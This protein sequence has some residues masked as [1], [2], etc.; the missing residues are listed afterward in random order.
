VRD[1][2]EAALDPRT[3]HGA[4]PAI[5]PFFPMLAAQ[6]KSEFL[7]LARAPAFTIPTIIFPIMF[8]ALFGLPHVDEQFGNS[9]VGRFMLASFGAYAVISVALFSFG[10]TVAAER[11]RK[12]TALMRSTPL[13][14]LAY[15]GGKTLATIA[16][17]LVTLIALF[18]FGAGVGGVRLETGQ[19]LA[20][21][22]VLLLGVFPFITLGFAVGYLAGGNSAVAILNL[23]NLPMAFGSG[24]FMPLPMLPLAVQQIAPYLPA[25]HYGQLAWSAVGAG[26]EPPLTAAI[27]LAGYGIAFLLLALRAYGR[28][29]VKEFG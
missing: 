9:T 5:A 15:L 12:T 18:A 14:P 23:I 7:M 8:F 17:A 20:L 27:W 4:V 16:F 28:E 2:N 19:W 13:R 3:T 10:V 1:R 21:F 25:Y 26:S 24:L 6:A 11:A 22:G 29:Q